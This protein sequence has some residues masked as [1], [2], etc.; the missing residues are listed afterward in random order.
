MKH[1]SKRTLKKQLISH[2][3]R[4]VRSVDEEIA[5]LKAQQELFDTGQYWAEV[6]HTLASDREQAIEMMKM[7]KNYQK[8][9]C[10]AQDNYTERILKANPE[11]LGTWD[12]GVMFLSDMQNKVKMYGSGCKF[13][14]KQRELVDKIL[15]QCEV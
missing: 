15:V 14:P 2:I 10:L 1:N 12:W 13:S 7:I 5:T 11:K 9:K 4:F 3:V 8:M 6:W